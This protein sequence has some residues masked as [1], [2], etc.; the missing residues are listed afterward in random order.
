[1]N[2]TNTALDFVYIDASAAASVVGNVSD[3]D[4]VYLTARRA[5]AK[6]RL[7]PGGGFV[8]LKGSVLSPEKSTSYLSVSLRTKRQ[9]KEGT[10]LSED[11]IFNTPSGA[12]DFLTGRSNNGWTVWKTKDGKTLDELYQFE[13]KVIAAEE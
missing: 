5:N 13:R 8:V 1:M 2:R 9:G 6:G 3:G 10:S 11:V 4:I 7:L 12:A